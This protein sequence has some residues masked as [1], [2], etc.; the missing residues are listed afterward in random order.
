MKKQEFAISDS[1]AALRRVAWENHLG[2]L[3]G[4]LYKISS[5]TVRSFNG[6]K[7]LSIG[8]R[9]TVEGN[10]DINDAVGEELIYD[11]SGGIKVIKGD[12]IGVVSC[13]SYASCK[14]C[15]GKVIQ[16]NELLEKCKMW[17][18]LRD[19]KVQ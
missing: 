18:H 13:E 1:T 4:K 5:A 19:G 15:D 12:I 17:Y 3:E 14:N 16:F 11:G 9:S 2:I 7:Y 10:D 6:A 8:E